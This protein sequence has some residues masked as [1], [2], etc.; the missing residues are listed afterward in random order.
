MLGFAMPFTSLSIL[1]ENAG[2]KPFCRAKPACFEFSLANFLLQGH[3][4]STDGAA[5]SYGICSLATNT[6]CLQNEI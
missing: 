3:T 5:L 6:R 1:Y 2:P 4:L